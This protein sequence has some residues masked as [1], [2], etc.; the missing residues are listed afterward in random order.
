VQKLIQIVYT[1]SNCSDVWEMFYFQNKKH[2]NL[3]LAWISDKETPSGNDYIYD[4]KDAY[5]QV[6]GEALYKAEPEYFIYLQEDFILCGDVNYSKINEYVNFLDRNPEYSFI[7]LFKCG[8]VSNE[9]VT[10]TLYKINSTDQDA[11]A[12]QATIWRTSDYKKLMVKTAEPKW[13]ETPKYREVMIQEN[14]RGLY[15][16]DNE[17]KIGN[18]HYGSNV[19][20]LILALSKGRWDISEYP[21]LAKLLVDYKIDAKKR[22]IR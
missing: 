6:W 22:G 4:N 8:L 11:F 10:D 20:P 16:Y 12:M 14:M 18:M 3:P 19:Y 21:E 13:L 15:H 5:W 7:R 17:P 9:K 2:A 1:N